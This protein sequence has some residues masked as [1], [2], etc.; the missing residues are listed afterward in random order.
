MKRPLLTFAFMFTLFDIGAIQAAT[1]NYETVK[2]IPGLIIRITG[3]P[4]EAKLL[5]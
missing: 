1:I 2:L 5:Q 4:G 3:L